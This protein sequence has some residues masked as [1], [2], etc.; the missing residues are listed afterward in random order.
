MALDYHC[1]Q[2]SAVKHRAH[3]TLVSAAVYG[4]DYSAHDTHMIT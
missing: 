2:T 4:I 1:N 3:V